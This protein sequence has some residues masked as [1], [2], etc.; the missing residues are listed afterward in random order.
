VDLLPERRQ[1]VVHDP[2]RR[3]RLRLLAPLFAAAI[4]AAAVIA[5]AGLGAPAATVSRTLDTALCPFPLRVTVTRKAADEVATTALQYVFAGASTITLQNVSTGRTATLVSSGSHDVDTR[6]GTISFHGHQVWY[7]STSKSIPFLATVG[8]G[9]L[10]APTYVLAPGSSQAR[11]IDPCARV[12]PRMPSTK[13]RTTPAPWG[14][15]AY[16]LSRIEYAG[17]TPLLGRIIR[18]DHVHL[19]VVVDGR[20]VAIPAGVGLAEP[21]DHGPCPPAPVQQG[22]CT[23]GHIYAAA[24]ANSPLHTHSASGIIHVEPDRPGS[25]TLGQFFDE[26]GVRLDSSCLGAYCAGKGRR[27]RAYVDGRRIRGNP[28]DIVLGNRQEIALVYG[29]RAAFRSVPSRWRKGWPG[30]GCGGAGEPRC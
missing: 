28:R 19:D 24:V 13:P 17:L 25:Y 27:L 3:R 10:V 15:P 12:S 18:H 29:T 21:V 11:V 7:W 9:R 4:L 8:T 23:T 1:A 16:T 26:W 6:T 20:H 14:L 22:D 5:S 30:L 2:G